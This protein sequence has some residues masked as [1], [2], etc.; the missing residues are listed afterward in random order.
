MAPSFTLVYI[1][2]LQQTIP[3]AV[4]LGA[5]GYLPYI[6]W[7]ATS[8]TSVP[9]EK[10]A[11]LL[12]T[13]Y[14]G[15]VYN[16]NF[17]HYQSSNCVRHR[18]RA[19]QMLA[20][21][22]EATATGRCAG[23]SRFGISSPSFKI[24][25]VGFLFSGSINHIQPSE[26]E[27]WGSNADQGLSSYRF[28][29]AMENSNMPGYI[30]EKILTAFLVGSIPIYYG[31]REIFEIFNE[32]SVQPTFEVLCWSAIVLSEGRYSFCRSA[33]GALLSTCCS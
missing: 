2:Q 15:D 23:I 32:V 4:H 18:E 11:Q 21:V 24:D 5:G 14:G 26:K 17:L 20:S 29:L 1:A 28:A 16:A 27:T 10:A 8:Y 22:G 13:N 19:F 7:A 25:P 31:T 33:F 12:R 9:L 3:D 6:S 30:T